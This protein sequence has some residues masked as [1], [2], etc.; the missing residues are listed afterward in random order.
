MSRYQSFVFVIIFLL[1]YHSS[2]GCLEQ[3][4]QALV[5]LK[6]SFNDPSFRLSS[7]EGNDCCKWKS[8]SCSNIT[9]H[10]V[11]IELR[12]PCYPQKGEDFQPNCSFSK[13]KLE[14]Q[15]VHP[16]LS[17]FKYLSYLDLS[18]NSFNSS[19][20]PTWFHSMNHLQHLSLSNSDFSGM[21]P[22]NLGNLTK[23]YFLDLSY[24]SWL[25]SDDI[26]WISKLSLLQYLYMTDVFLGKIINLMPQI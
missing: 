7:W 5:E 26:Y 19:P 6:G 11:K 9:K 8:I 2:F 14:S 15:Y 20:I 21:I 1:S 3:E 4:R 23:L 13:Y 12:N 10:V 18:G 24:N 17:K 16:S 25:H 22:N